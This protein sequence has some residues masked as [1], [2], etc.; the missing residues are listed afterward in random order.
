MKS[1]KHLF[2]IIFILLVTGMQTVVLAQ[3]PYISKVWQA[4]NEDGSYK[5]PIL[6]A[7]Y[8][9]PD[10]IRIG[11]DYYMVA[12][13]FNQVPGLPILHSTDLV[14]WKII[15]HGLQRLPL[16]DHYSVVR[17]GKGVWAPSFSLHNGYVYIYYPDPDYGIFMIKSKDP[18]G[19]WSA[20]VLVLK[21]KG[22]IDPSVLWDEDGKGY[23]AIGWA[24][25]RAGVNSLLTIFQLNEDGTAVIDAGRHVYDGHEKDPTVE[26]PKLYKR[27]G[28]YY[29]FCP[30]G[31]VSTGWQLA[32]R[33]KDIYGP[34]ERKVVMSQ[35]NT[36][37]NG[38]HQGAWIHTPASQDWFIH[39]QDKGAY[40]R[41]TLLEPLVWKNNWPVIG[42]DKD[43]DGCGEPVSVYSK[44]IVKEKSIILTPSE[45]DSF[46]AGGIGKQ[47]QW[48]A[49][50]M[51]QW[52][53]A[54]RHTGYLRLF[55]IP[56]DTGINLYNMPNLLLQ[57]FPAPNFTATTKVKW[58]IEWNVWQGK[59]AG[60]MI[61][62]DSYAYLSIGKDSSGFFV[63]QVVCQEASTDAKEKIVE[64][65]HLKDSILYMRVKVNGPDAIC[66]FSYSE[67]NQHFHLIGQPFKARPDLWIGAK[68]G[69]FCTSKP[70][71]RTGG[72]ADFDDFSITAND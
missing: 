47:W 72:Y 14:N 8:S 50:P 43:G 71:V 41:V 57:K 11:E 44:P 3:S 24:A 59:K 12:S 26:G 20:P 22:I 32:L 52:Y 61:S 2:G 6:Y 5:N 60:L 63:C 33:S 66:N 46:N 37:I 58:N 38:P 28:Y 10:V 68:V 40:G 49:N 13:S 18:S 1:L 36:N 69:L 7:D 67:D 9:D 64:R 39:F 70:D 15:G 30:A 27:N 45:N 65:R 23:M 55:A 53:A 62:G 17:H 42:V 48:Q 51:I 31:G 16:G 19:S 29:I 4:D 34:Y 56:T 35:G 54:L 25:S 21:G